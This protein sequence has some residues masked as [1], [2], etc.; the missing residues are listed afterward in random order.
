MDRIDTQNILGP[1][2]KKHDFSR[3]KT[4]IILRNNKENFRYPIILPF[5]QRAALRIIYEKHIK[6]IRHAE[7]SI[8]MA[9]P[10]RKFLDIKI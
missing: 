7:V 4:N 9:Q 6:K 10:K 2:E 3:S 8:L 5:K 1:L